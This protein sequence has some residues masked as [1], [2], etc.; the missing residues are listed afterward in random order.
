MKPDRPIK[1]NVEFYAAPVI[2]GTGLAP[3]LFPAA[4][5]LG[6]LTLPPGHPKEPV[7]RGGA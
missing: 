1:T 2:A 6:R 4:F 5:A 3:E 7:S